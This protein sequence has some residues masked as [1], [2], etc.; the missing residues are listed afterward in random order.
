MNLNIITV[1]GD[2]IEADIIKLVSKTKD[3]SFEICYNHMPIIINTIAA[4]TILYKEGS[5]KSSIFTSEGILYVNNNKLEFCCNSAEWPQ[6][7]DQSRAEMAL[8]RAEKRIS[9]NHPDVN[10]ER[11][12]RSLARAMTRLQLKSRE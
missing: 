12:K 2:V 4:E 7:I 3:G 6:D 5:E 1:S 8:N 9:E 11:A 10:I